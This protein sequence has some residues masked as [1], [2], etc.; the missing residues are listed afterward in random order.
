MARI[1][2]IMARKGQKLVLDALN[3]LVKVAS[4][5]VI[6]TDSFSKEGIACDDQLLFWK[7]KG[8]TAPGVAR[9]LDHLELEAFQVIGP[10]VLKELFCWLTDDIRQVIVSGLAREII[11][12]R[13]EPAGFIF[14]HING[15]LAKACSNPL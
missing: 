3:Q 5:Q 1:D 8:N 13:V 2:P 9:G 4:R 15:R 12:R 10:I 14:R 11:Q 7:D 6:A